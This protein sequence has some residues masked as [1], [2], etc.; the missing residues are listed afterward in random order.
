MKISMSSVRSVLAGRDTLFHMT[1]ISSAVSILSTGRFALKPSDGTDA[2]ERLGKAAYYLS[3]ARTQYNRF[4]RNSVWSY[5]V[6]FVLDGAKMSWRYSIKPVDYWQSGADNKEHEERV[7]SNQPFLPIAGYIKELHAGVNEKLGPLQR[8]ALKLKIPLYL[9]DEPKY[10]L[11][12]DKRK[13]VK[14]PLQPVEEKTSPTLPRR[15]SDLKPW[16]ILFTYPKQELST[17]EKRKAVLAKMPKQVSMCYRMLDYPGDAE[18]SLNADLHNAKSMPHG[19]SVKHREDLD[20]MI[21]ILRKN[22]LTVTQFVAQLK[23]KWYPKEDNS[24]GAK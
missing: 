8:L 13:A 23:A 2:E 24:W 10:L 21:A 7:F 4:A 15:I 6:V 12:L 19:A 16:I 5:S 11:S 20:S 14:T 17:Y 3:T 1:T 22:R 9:Y 18:R